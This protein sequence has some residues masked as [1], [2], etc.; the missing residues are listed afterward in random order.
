MT[1]D[2]K[3][4][5]NLRALSQVFSP[6]MFQKI[7][8]ENDF[9]P[10][11]KKIIKHLCEKQANSNLE[12]IKI[13]YRYLLKQYR[14]EYI[15]KNKLFIDIIKEHGLK[16]TLTIN[17]LKVG[18]SKADLVL[19]NGSIRIYEIKTELD[20]LSKLSKQLN[21]YQKFADKVYIVTDDSYAKKLLLEYKDT[22]IGLI[23]LNDK[24]KLETVKDAKDNVLSFDFDVIFKI[25]RKQEYLDLV[26]DNFGVVP[27]LPNTK[28]FKACYELLSSIEIEGL[29]KQVLNKLKERKLLKPDLLQSPNT[30]K[31][32]KHICNTLDFDEQEYQKLYKFLAKQSLCISLI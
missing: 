15:Y 8:R 4:I 19:L 22:N 9:M 7:V 10:F 6:S 27:D 3:S 11:E 23:A 25:L 20:G 17:E 30:P 32:L 5:Q 12:V 18:A 21:D 29:Q 1:N 14:C 26:R 2:S 24:N 31:E 16:D 28:I 13:L